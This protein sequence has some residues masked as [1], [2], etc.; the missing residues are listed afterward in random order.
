MLG[1]N[2]LNSTPLNSDFALQGDGTIPGVLYLNI[3]SNYPEVIDEIPGQDLPVG[4]G[5]A[6]GVYQY[7]KTNMWRSY[8]GSARPGGGTFTSAAEGRY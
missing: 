3:P 5:G 4:M 1:R 2:L 8:N 6:P 7:H